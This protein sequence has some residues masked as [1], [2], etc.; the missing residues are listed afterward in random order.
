VA[1]SKKP[2]HFAI[3][4]RDLSVETANS[5]LLAAMQSLSKKAVFKELLSQ[6]SVFITNL[7]MACIQQQQV[8]AD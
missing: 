7:A 8:T 4:L 5:R 2:N 6:P 3:D 1:V